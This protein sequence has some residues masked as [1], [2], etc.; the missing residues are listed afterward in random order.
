MATM[1]LGDN[2]IIDCDAA[3]FLEGEEV[4]RL[5]DRLK[6]GQLVVD[7]DLRAENGTRIAKISKSYD[8]HVVEGYE[9]RRGPNWAEVVERSTGRIVAR[10]DATSLDTVRVVGTF[11]VRGFK[12]VIAEDCL[13]SGGNVI[14]RNTVNGLKRAIALRR[15]A[16]MI[17]LQ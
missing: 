13:V 8:A 7:F 4:L 2:E 14:S 15:G 11:N 1:I 9:H 5:R 17:G 12:V 16:A 6:D 10:V 3:L